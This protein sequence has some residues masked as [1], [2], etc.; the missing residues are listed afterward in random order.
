VQADQERKLAA[1]ARKE[2]R[3]TGE[4]ETLRSRLRELEANQKE[5][6]EEMK[7]LRRSLRQKELSM[8]TGGPPGGG[9]GGGG[10][11]RP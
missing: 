11:L 1:E 4:I 2:R 10:G 9:G 8:L 5:K 7:G 3:Q 6:E